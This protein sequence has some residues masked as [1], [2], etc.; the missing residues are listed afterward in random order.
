MKNEEFHKELEQ[1]LKSKIDELAESV[2]CFDKIS[3]RAFPADNKDFSESGFTVT[4]LETVSSDTKRHHIVRWTA[5]AGAAAAAI[6][7]LPK[8]GIPQRALTKLGV[9]SSKCS[10]EAILGEIESQTSDGSYHIIDVPLEYYI[11]NDILVTPLMRCPFEETDRDDAN[12]RLYIKQIDGWDTNQ[13]YAIEYLGTYSDNDIVAAAKS[14]YTFTAEELDRKLPD[15]ADTQAL[16]GTSAYHSFFG[17]DEGVLTDAWDTAVS[18]ASFEYDSV[19]KDE[20][21]VRKLKTEI[22]YGTRSEFV[23]APENFYDIM[24]HTSSD[25]PAIPEADKMWETSVY[26]NGNSAFP[27]KSGSSYTRETLF[28][29]D[30]SDALDYVAMPVSDDWLP[31]LGMKIGLRGTVLQNLISTVTCPANPSAAINLKLYFS[32]DTMLAYDNATVELVDCSGTAPELVHEYSIYEI[33]ENM[34]DA[35]SMTPEMEAELREQAVRTEEEQIMR[36]AEAEKEKAYQEMN[37][38]IDNQ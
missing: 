3:E 32:I 9:N 23:K 1:L 36:L 5:L 19:V 37:K 26:F 8:T 2:D 6:F 12:V 27:E 31:P 13:V 16:A 30:M 10:Y 20:S 15:T 25:E 18:L 38:T 4:D 34:F 14:K 17:G 24:T 35:E 33:N 22:I 11:E 21:G 28:T 29:E 7:L